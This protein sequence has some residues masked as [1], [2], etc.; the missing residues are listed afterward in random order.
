MVCAGT[1]P[2]VAGDAVWGRT[3]KH[4]RTITASLVAGATVAA[5]HIPAS[6]QPG[7]RWSPDRKRYAVTE[8]GRKFGAGE[9]RERIVVYT[10][11]GVRAAIAHVLAGRARRSAPC[12]HPRM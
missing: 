12:R 4:P 5:L 1:A 6:A 3:M 9:E 10:N 11:A 7:R 2:A 8:A